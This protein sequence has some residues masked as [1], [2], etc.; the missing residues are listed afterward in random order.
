[1][2]CGLKWWRLFNNRYPA[3][4]KRAAQMC[5]SPRAHA[6]LTTQEWRSFLN[7]KLHPSVS[8]VNM[9]PQ[10]VYN[11]DESGY[12]RNL[13]VKIVKMVARKGRRSIASRRGYICTHITAMVCVSRTRKTGAPALLYTRKKN[14]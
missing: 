2:S 1:M 6:R 10:H 7:D 11:Q 3:L 5:E 9:K 8:R 13:L 4:K 14:A 12:F